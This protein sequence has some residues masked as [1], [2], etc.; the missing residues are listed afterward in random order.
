MS[1]IRFVRTLLLTGT[2]ALAA[3]GTH[4]QS[5]APPD[6]RQ[7]VKIDEHS[8]RARPWDIVGSWFGTTATGIRQ[9]LMFH[10]DG[11]VLRSVQG[12][13]STNPAAPPHTPAF[14]VWRYLGKGRFGVTMWD[15][16]YDV[17]TLQPIRY[18]RLRLELTIGEDRN[19]ASANAIIDVID[20]QGAITATRTGTAT[21]ARILFEP[22][23]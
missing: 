19:T 7:D 12:E 18:N 14:G 20:L 22:F 1:T 21:F 23:Q 10:A 11:T 6:Q 17:N 13:V 5:V 8:Q 2:L 15:L 4:A 9:L 3:T 16:F